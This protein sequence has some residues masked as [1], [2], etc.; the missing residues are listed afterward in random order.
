MNLKEFKNILK[1]HSEKLVGFRLPNG[2][3]APLHSHI[4]EAG[5][6]AKN[7]IDCGGTVRRT[8]SCLLQLWEGNDAGHRISAG[9]LHGILQTARWII[10]NDEL[11]VEIEYEA[12][13]ISQYPVLAAQVAGN[14]LRFIVET[15]HA[16]CLAR[17]T[18]GT[19]HEDASPC[20]GN[21]EQCC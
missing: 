18:C 16:D 13:I 19:G 1:A 17:Q 20:C 5:H 14:V 6:M 3:T 15:K 2:E 21:T 12:G 7:F 4:T 9:K 8:E 10:P 11:D